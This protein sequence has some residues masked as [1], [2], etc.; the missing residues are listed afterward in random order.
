LKLG[1]H[2]PAN[3]LP[4]RRVLDARYR[5]G[6]ALRIVSSAA[7]PFRSA[8]TRLWP[9]HLFSK[10]VCAD[11]VCVFQ[12]RQFR[13]QPSKNSTIKIASHGFG[14]QFQQ[15]GAARL[16]LPL[17]ARLLE[18]RTVMC[19]RPPDSDQATRSPPASPSVTDSKRRRGRRRVHRAVERLQF[20]RRKSPASVPSRR[21]RMWSRFFGSFAAPRERI[22]PGQRF[23]SPGEIGLAILQRFISGSGSRSAQFAASRPGRHIPC[24]G[25]DVFYHLS[26][27]QHNIQSLTCRAVVP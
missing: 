13:A 20:S 25:R 23:K 16:K 18:E 19:S 27:R 3:L 10:C 22:K 17:P 15:I 8:H 21:A 7:P 2:K 14:I 24:R 9:R 26:V 4:H 6:V 5:L 1:R 12:Q 11:P